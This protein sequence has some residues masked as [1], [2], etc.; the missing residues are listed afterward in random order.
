MIRASKL[1]L[2]IVCLVLAAG[3]GTIWGFGVGGVGSFVSSL[4][5]EPQTYESIIV[6]RDGSPLIQSRIGG[7][8]YHQQ[9]RTLD[10]T[11]VS[12]EK[13]DTM[14]VVS[15]NER[16]RAPGIVDWPITWQER[17]AGMSD[18]RNPPN[19]W[20]L[21]RDAESEGRAYITGHDALTNYSLG[22]I[23]REGSRE[24]VPAAEEWFDLGNNRLDWNTN[25]VTSGGS[26]DFGSLGLGYNYPA[27]DQQGWFQPWQVFLCD[28]NTVREINLRDRQIRLVQDFEQLVGVAVAV[29][30]VVIPGAPNDPEQSSR[31]EQRLLVRCTDRLIVFNPFEVTQVDFKIPVG[32]ENKPFSVHTI[33][34]ERLMLHIDRGYWEQGNVVE[35]QTIKPNGEVERQDTVRLLNYVPS[36]SGE[37]ALEVAAIAPTLLPWVVGVIAVAPLIFIQN[38]QAETYQQALGKSLEAWPGLLLVFV[39]SLILAALVFHWQK[40]YSRPHTGL[41][42]TFVFLTTLPG[43]LGYWAMHRKP[44]LAACPSC[45]GEVPRNRDACAKCAEP[46]PEP[47]LLGSE[48]FA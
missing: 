38:L 26:V 45:G 25:V 14:S 28:G 23:G 2:V 30:H 12:P 17:I 8:Y 20:V 46:F 35:L 47:K 11:P 3:F 37:Q 34:P 10:D 21:I 1:R 7:N 39:V 4:F 42:T 32:L 27:V 44:L 24:T 41:W 31:I 6:A 48:I 5:A 22:Y 13:L 18:S 9:I 33:G 40:K 43:F 29:L 15:M 19:S 16:Y 36:T